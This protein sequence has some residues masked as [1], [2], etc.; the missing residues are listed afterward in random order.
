MGPGF[1][2][3]LVLAYYASLN[4]SLTAARCLLE[5]VFELYRQGFTANDVELA[6]SVA[7]DQ[8]VVWV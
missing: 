8:E 7:G 6:L 3:A 1:V 5:V 4:R 2:R